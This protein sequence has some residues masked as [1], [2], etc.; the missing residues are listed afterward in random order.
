MI[1]R[2]EPSC[3]I[4]TGFGSAIQETG[5]FRPFFALIWMLSSCVPLGV[6]TPLIPTVPVGLRTV[7]R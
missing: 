4:S 1:Q 7:P 6:E 2:A 3:T 5:A